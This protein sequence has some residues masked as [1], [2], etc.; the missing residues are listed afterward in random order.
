MREDCEAIQPLMSGYLDH[1]LS[2]DNRERLE[3][4]LR[5]CKTCREEFERMKRLIN[6]ASGLEVEPPPEEVWDTFIEGVYNRIER[7]TGWLVVILGAA[8]LAAWGIYVFLTEPWGSVLEK[9]LVATPVVGLAV[10][11]VSIL[12]ER[13]FVAKTDRYSKE[14]KR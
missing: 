4:H 9:L 3:G 8:A 6:A 5:S 1:E 11:F 10:V 13:L 2:D 12:R 7:Q 14:V